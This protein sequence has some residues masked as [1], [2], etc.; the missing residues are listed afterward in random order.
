MKPFD[1]LVIHTGHLEIQNGQGE[2]F[3]AAICPKG[4]SLRDGNSPVVCIWNHPAEVTSLS[5]AIM[6]TFG[7][8][9][10]FK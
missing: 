8:E 4:S 2:P 10:S 6:T 5:V 3:G 7:K 1:P 9:I